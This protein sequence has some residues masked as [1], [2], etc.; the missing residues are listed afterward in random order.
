MTRTLM[1]L[2]RPQLIGQANW[3][4]AL[5]FMCGNYSIAMRVDRY[6]TVVYI[7]IPILPF[8]ERRTIGR[9]DLLFTPSNDI[10][11]VQSEI[12][13]YPLRA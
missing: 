2:D 10:I 1:I 6:Y 9:L 7:C 3:D 4:L 12:S 11:G 5:Y 13:S 8:S